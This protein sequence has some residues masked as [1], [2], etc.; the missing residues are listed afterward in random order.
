MAATLRESYGDDKV[1]PRFDALNV[2]PDAHV[3]SAMAHAHKVL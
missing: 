2:I 1:T 3:Y